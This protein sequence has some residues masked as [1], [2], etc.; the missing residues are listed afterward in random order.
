MSVKNNVSHEFRILIKCLICVYILANSQ[1]NKLIKD[2]KAPAHVLRWYNFI[3]S[4][5][6]V[7]AAIAR[8]PSSD[9][10]SNKKSKPE[11]APKSQSS[12]SERK[13]EGKF[14]KLP[15][16]EKGHVVVRF[17]PEASG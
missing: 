17:P 15:N 7:T 1:W 13:Q 14:L 9:M 4:L 10:S 12:A 8:L 16:A 2:G 3:N 11:S 6:C 5:E